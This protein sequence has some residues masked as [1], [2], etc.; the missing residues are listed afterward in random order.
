VFYI[1]GENIPVELTKG[2]FVIV[3]DGD[4]FSLVPDSYRF[5]VV[6]PSQVD[7]NHNGCVEAVDNTAKAQTPDHA[8]ERH[9]P[10]WMTDMA[11]RDESNSS[12]KASHPQKREDDRSD[13]N[14]VIKKLKVALKDSDASGEDTSLAGVGTPDHDVPGSKTEPERAKIHEMSDDEEGGSVKDQEL[15]TEIEESSAKLHDMSDDEEGSSVKDQEVK[16]EI[17]ESS[18][19]VANTAAQTGD[20]STRV[21]NQ[22]TRNVQKS[23]CIYG[24]KCYR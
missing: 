17:K 11:K 24:A 4:E 7:A 20:P 5:R 1:R 8:Y 3:S 16:T 13:E 10:S 19:D 12:V 14:V 22:G 6:I 2:D 18:E 21:T 23:R 15:K 9:L